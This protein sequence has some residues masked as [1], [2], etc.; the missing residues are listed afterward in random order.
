M[1]GYVC[2][3]IK[4]GEGGVRIRSTRTENVEVAVQGVHALE[5]HT[6]DLGSQCS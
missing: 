3:S 6:M 5:I 2:T 1:D 4:D